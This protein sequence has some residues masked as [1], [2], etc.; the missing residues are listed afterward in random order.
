M[1]ALENITYGELHE[2]DYATFTR[3]LTEEELVLFAAASG[4]VNPAS[5]DAEYASQTS[6]KERIGHGMWTGSLISAALSTVMPGPGTIHLEQKLKF[7]LPVKVGDT[8]TVTL[9]V[10][11]KGDRNRVTFKCEVVNHNNELVVEGESVV[12]AP[13]EKVTLERPTLPRIQIDSQ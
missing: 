2:G 11:E 5:L 1:H 3:T 8:L 13:T 7:D 12:V 9:T 10:K 4:D 6:N